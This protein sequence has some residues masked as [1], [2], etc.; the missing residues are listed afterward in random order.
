MSDLDS[1]LDN[2]V[3]NLLI[4]IKGMDKSGREAQIAAEIFLVCKEFGIEKVIENLNPESRS[5]TP[6][7]LWLKKMINLARRAK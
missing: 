6:L 2:A 1:E 4:R 7:I 5:Q 3:S